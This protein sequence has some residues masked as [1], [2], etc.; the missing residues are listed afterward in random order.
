MQRIHTLQV[1]AGH[2]HAQHGHG[3]LGSNHA[4]QVGRA[5]RASDDGLEATFSRS[6]CVAE[7]V[8]RH[9][10]GRNH[11]RLKS[12]TEL[13]EDGNCVL[14]GVPVAAGTHDHTDLDGVHV[15]SQRA[16]AAQPSGTRDFTGKPWVGEWTG[17]SPYPLA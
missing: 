12:D 7:H 16:L 1:A 9:A 10:V 8:I 2:G 13:L 14:H 17:G 5:A 3:G 15:L 11:L 6:F 4:G